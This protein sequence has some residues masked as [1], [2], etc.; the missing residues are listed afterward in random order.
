MG[1]ITM[2]QYFK[3][4]EEKEINEKELNRKLCISLKCGIL[5]YAESPK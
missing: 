2:F 4:Y 3:I 5:S 1:Y